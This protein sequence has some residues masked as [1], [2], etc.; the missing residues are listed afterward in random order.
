MYHCTLC[1]V[2][3]ALNLSSPEHDIELCG[4][5][6]DS[7]LVERG[8][9]F[10]ALFGEK[11]DGHLFLAD[12]RARGAVAAVVSHDYSGA[13]YGLLLLRVPRVLLALQELARLFL[14]SRGCRVVGVTGSVGKTTT[15]GFVVTLLEGSYRVSA[16]ARSYNGQIGLPLS[17]LNSSGDEELLVLEMG[18]S[19]PGE[20]AR[21]VAIAPPDVA[22]VNSIAPVHIGQFDSVEQI[23]HEKAQL[24]SSPLTQLGIVNDEMPCAELVRGMGSCDKL[25]Y[26]LSNAASDYYVER[27][28]TSLVVVDKEGRHPLPLPPLLGVHNN[29]NL[30]GAIAV[31]RHY[32]VEWEAIGQQ[33][34]M[35]SLPPGR[36]EK[37]ERGGVVVI[38][39][40]YNAN[41]VATVAALKS[42]SLVE[43]QGKR[44]AVLGDML[45][46]GDFFASHHKEVGRVALDCVDELFCYGDGGKEMAAVWRDLPKT[47]H[48]YEDK[49]TMTRALLERVVAGDLVLVKGSRGCKMETVVEAIMDLVDR[50]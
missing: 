40:T 27:N 18:M 42:L 12:A 44:Y 41:L 43:K 50:R 37:K 14:L 13:G 7:R 16:S 5:A 19:L 22:L 31:A 10:F 33:I 35:L 21:L 17:I 9:L 8:S 15:K 4:Y 39:D 28:E 3:K 38:D 25:G 46:L 2:A 30:L 49:E 29:D 36:L 45:E 1:T 11:V 24:F 20:I 34:P 6:V 26:S 23:A 48:C 32:G 47:V